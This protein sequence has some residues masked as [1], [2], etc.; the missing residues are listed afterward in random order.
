MIP[1]HP[2]EIE[3]ET[4]TTRRTGTCTGYAAFSRARLIF[5]PENR[6]PSSYHK[7]SQ[8]ILIFLASLCQCFCDLTYLRFMHEGFIIIFCTLDDNLNL[9]LHLFF[10]FFPLAFGSLVLPLVRLLSNLGVCGGWCVCAPDRIFSLLPCVFV[11][12]T[13]CG[14][15]LGRGGGAHIIFR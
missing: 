1:C 5:Y 15:C 6:T 11:V 2:H 12:S 14:C 9:N 8:L 10:F 4:S 7:L 3:I 13:F